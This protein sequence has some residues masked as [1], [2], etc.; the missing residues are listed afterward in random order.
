MHIESQFLTHSLDVLETFL[1]IG[2]GATDPDLHFVL[3][4]AVGDF[5]E[6]AD[7]AFEG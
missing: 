2:A 3:V 1:V 7:Y 5:A 6:G 4:Q